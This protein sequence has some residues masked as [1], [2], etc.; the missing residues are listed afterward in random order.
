MG[1]GKGQIIP[2]TSH[3]FCIS[4]LPPSISLPLDQYRVAQIEVSIICTEGWF[5][6]D[7]FPI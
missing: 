6:P 1:G 2:L 5:T 7:M 3:E 4:P